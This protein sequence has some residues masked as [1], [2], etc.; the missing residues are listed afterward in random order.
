VVTAERAVVWVPGLVALAAI[1]CS[2][3]PVA[4]GGRISGFVAVTTPNNALALTARASSEGVDSV[5][6]VFW[7]QGGAPEQTPCYPAAVAT[8]GMPVLG[9]APGSHYR[10]VAQECGDPAGARSD[11]V[12]ANTGNLPPDLANVDLGV[13]GDAPEGLVLLPLRLDST[14]YLVAFDGSGALRWYRQVEIRP[15]DLLGDIAQLSNGDFTIFVGQTPGWYPSYGRYYQLGPTG[16]LT[17]TYTAPAPYYTDN[18]EMLI[19]FAGPAVQYVHLFG[20]DIRQVDL[21]SLGGP[22]DARV[23]GH[24][25]VRFTP[26]GR[27]DFLWNAWDHLSL[28]DWY[29]PPLPGPGTTSIDFDHPN[30]LDIDRDGNYVVSWRTLG[31][32]TKIDSRDG[33]ILWRLGGRNNMFTFVNDA[34]GGFSAQHDA[35]VLPNG[36]LLLYDNGW[37]HNPP[38]TRIVEY[39]LDTTAMTATL[40]WEFRRTPPV[41][42]PIVGAAQRLQNGNTFIA[43]GTETTV[44]EISPEKALVWEGQLRVG[45]APPAGF[46]YRARRIASLYAYARP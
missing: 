6:V 13:T 33:R 27:V 31:E 11:T 25:I 46:F 14:G 3:A 37:R 15:G 4:P 36:N 17:A 10:L 41:F 23:A 2:D 35:R 7:R 42:T 19:T 32:V 22:T 26:T 24:Q 1:G 8:T 16:D 29:E 28:D 9:L 44:L 5:M 18:H 39:E 38:E 43:Y 40:V 45:G 30:S 12:T 20:Y 34:F 21:S